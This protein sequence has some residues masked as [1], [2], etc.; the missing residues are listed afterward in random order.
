M[1]RAWV[2]VFILSINLVLIFFFWQQQNGHANQSGPIPQDAIRLRILA[3]SDSPADQAVKVQIRDAVNQNITKWVTDLKQ[4][5]QAELVIRQHLPELR[6]IVAQTLKKVHSDQSFHVRLGKADFPTKLYGNYVYPAGSYH[7]LVITLGSGQG[8]NWWCVLFPP[9]C[10]LDFSNSEA[11][12]PEAQ[13]STVAESTSPRSHNDQ[14]V[15]TSE[16]KARTIENQQIQQNDQSLPQAQ[17]AGSRSAS[18]TV[19]VRSLAA[20]I[21]TKLFHFLN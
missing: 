6:Q 20:D 15:E 1:K 7:A 3:N 18:D 4:S 10:F 8:A 19:Q 11:V 9:L 5:T 12:R 2:I 16:K 14:Q 21:I 17:A 13:Q